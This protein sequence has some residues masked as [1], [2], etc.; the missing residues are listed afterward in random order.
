MSFDPGVPNEHKSIEEPVYHNTATNTAMFVTLFAV[1]LLATSATARPIPDGGETH[2]ST[3]VI[4]YI[5]FE[6]LTYTYHKDETDVITKDVQKTTITGLGYNGDTGKI[7]VP[8]G[9]KNINVWYPCIPRDEDKFDVIGFSPVIETFNKNDIKIGEY[10]L[11]NSNNNGIDKP[12]GVDV[13]YIKLFA[14]KGTSWAA[15]FYNLTMKIES[16]TLEFKE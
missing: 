14:G 11:F 2:A 9:I 10:E 13:D 1:A 7:T 6:N 5:K 8:E 4:H 15:E 3:R 16:L 12:I